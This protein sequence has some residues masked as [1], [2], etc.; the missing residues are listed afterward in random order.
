VDPSRHLGVSVSRRLVLTRPGRISRVINEPWRSS[1]LSH[2]GKAASPPPP[3]H[4]VSTSKTWCPSIAISQF[5]VIVSLTL[6]VFSPSSSHLLVV[7]LFH[8]L[9]VLQLYLLL[10]TLP[11]ANLSMSIPTSH[12]FAIS[13]SFLL[14]CACSCSLYTSI[15]YNI[16]V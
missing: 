8:C 14:V 13:I 16:L 3:L 6:L 7:L 1:T 2:H 12:L 10:S 15:Y 11:F 4:T 5:L 9:V